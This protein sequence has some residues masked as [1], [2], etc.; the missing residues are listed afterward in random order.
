MAA[1]KT[2]LRL[3]RYDID[4]YLYDTFEG[5]PEPSHA[6]VNARTGT[7]AADTYRALKGQGWCESPLEEVQRNMASTGYP[8]ERLHYIKGMVEETVPSV[9]PDAISILRL[10][11]D[12]YESTKHE[13]EHL[14]PRLAR[15]GVLIIDDYGHWDGARKAIDEYL[16]AH[17][18]QILLHR[19]D[20]TARQGVKL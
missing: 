7:A 11:T 19:V 18:V 15:G 3:G 6:D 14:F 5:M 12:W 10:D 17:K 9:A 2:F 8:A 16:A 4:L 20:Y 1:A 13:M